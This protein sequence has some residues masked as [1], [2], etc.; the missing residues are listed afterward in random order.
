M[1]LVAIV[2]DSTDLKSKLFILLP[3]LT[4]FNPN[5]DAGMKEVREGEES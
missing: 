1:W 3:H 5:A 2:L 4:V